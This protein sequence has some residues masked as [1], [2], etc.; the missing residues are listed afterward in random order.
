MR[1]IKNILTQPNPTIG[2]KKKK[3]TK[4]PFLFQILKIH[5]KITPSVISCRY[6]FTE[7]GN[8][9]QIVDEMKLIFDS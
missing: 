6:R 2:L 5:Y 1:K 8:Y 3:L 7:K 4:N 9:F